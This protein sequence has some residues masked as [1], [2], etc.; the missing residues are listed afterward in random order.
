VPL[1]RTIEHAWKAPASLRCRRVLANVL[2]GL[3]VLILSAKVST[4]AE[5]GPAIGELMKG[6]GK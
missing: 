2:A 5:Q 6:G 3:A 4:A 1:R